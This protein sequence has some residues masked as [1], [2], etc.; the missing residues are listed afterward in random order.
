MVPVR[1]KFPLPV[2]EVTPQTRWVRIPGRG[3]AFVLDIAGPTPDA[4]TVFLVHGLAATAYLNWFTTL[5]ALSQHYRVVATDLSWHGRG[6]PTGRFRLTDCA[7]DAAAL[8]RLLGVRETIVIGYSMGG[9]VAQTLWRRHPQLVSGMVLCSTSGRWAANP[10]ERIFFPVLGAASHP[11]A[12]VA[13]PRIA[14]SASALRRQSPAALDVADRAREELRGL[15]LWSVPE[16]LAELGRFD[17]TPWLGEV[18]VPSA[19]VITARDKAIAPAR[20]HE[21]ADA[22]PGASRHVA[23]GGHTSILF[24]REQWLPVFL[25]AVREVSEEI[26]GDVAETA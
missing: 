20:Q 13:A 22:I 4:P 19:V 6:I 14:R 9:A 11:L 1:R 2:V 10:G 21:L 26:A 12:R 15:S 3:R 8:L 25:G 24:D 16:V 17:A 23:P 7:D 5:D 18:D